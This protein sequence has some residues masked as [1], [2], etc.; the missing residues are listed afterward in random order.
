MQNKLSEF[1]KDTIEQGLEEFQRDPNRALYLSTLEIESISDIFTEFEPALFKQVKSLDLT[2]CKK[3]TNLSGIEV[4]ESLVELDLYSCVILETL[5]GLESLTEI[6]ELSLQNCNSLTRLSELNAL[7]QLSNLDLSYNSWLTDFSELMTLTNLRKLEAYDCENLNSLVGLEKLTQLSHLDLDGSILENLEGIE[8][9]KL[10]EHLDVRN[11]DNLTEITPLAS[12]TSLKSLKIGSESLQSLTPIENLVNLEDLSL[13]W[14]ACNIN[15]VKFIELHKLKELKVVCCTNLTGLEELSNAKQLNKLSLHFQ[16]LENIEFIQSLTNLES[17]SLYNNNISKVDALLDLTNLKNLRLNNNS[18]SN[19]V[20]IKQLVERLQEC[21]I[22]LKGNPFVSSFNL[23]LNDFSPDNEIITSLCYRLNQTSDRISVLPSKV[24][25]LGNHASGKSSL[26]HYLK[27]GE[28][29][30][31]GNSTHILQIQRYD[32]KPQK[33][34]A[35]PSALI[36]DFGGQDYYHGLYRVFMS[37]KAVTCLLWQP[38]TNLNSIKKDSNDYFTQHFSR[39]YWLGYWQYFNTQ[40]EQDTLSWLDNKPPLLLVQTHGD[41]YKVHQPSACEYM[42]NQHLLCLHPESQNELAQASLSYFKAQL[43]ELIEA[44]QIKVQGAIW[45]EEFLAFI[46]KKHKQSAKSRKNWLGTPFSE[47]LGK[48]NPTDPDRTSRAQNLKVELSQLHAQ[49]IV[50]FYPQVN[51]SIVWLNPMAFAY[52]VHNKLLGKDSIKKHLGVMPDKLLKDVDQD[53]IKV[54]EKEKV[55]FHHQYGEFGPE[56]IVPNYLPLVNDSEH[57]YH[58]FTFGLQTSF[59]FGLWFKLYL[60]LGL[61]NQLVCHFGR[62]PDRKKFWRDQLLFTLEQQSKVLIKL[63]FNQQLQI[64]VFVEN[65]NPQQREQHIAYIY[66]VIMSL[67]YDYTPVDN[68]HEFSTRFSKIALSRSHVIDLTKKAK[69]EL[70]DEQAQPP[71]LTNQQLLKIYTTPPEDLWISRDKVN[72]INATA[73]ANIT[74]ETSLACEQKTGVTSEL[75]K[76]SLALTPFKP[77]THKEPNKRL[78]VFISYSH[79]DIEARKALQQY[80]ITLERDGVIDVWQD[81]MIST[82]ADWHNTI[83]EA[84]EKADVAIMLVSQSF[85]GSSYIHSVEMPTILKNMV[86]TKAKIFPVLI[87]QCD[88]ENWKVLPEQVRTNT[89]SENASEVNLSSYQFFP[90]YKKERLMPINQWTYPEEAWTQLA[91]KLREISGN[92]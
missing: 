73:L 32:I 67:Y 25:L 27:D 60:P 89:Q 3:L 88:Y 9:L 49:G 33:K 82:G 12:L 77:F 57:E 1:D 38:D 5:S 86:Q 83:V 11:C 58:L 14:L 64:Q 70:D 41:K 51:D 15:L 50:L 34:T 81:A 29:S 30:H 48:F 4:F 20:E 40:C 63:V 78:K 8:A 74:D 65:D 53:I 87:S 84:L 31:D 52:Y 76:T 26:A 61:I 54:L 79:D 71:T 47:V 75:A 62:L 68:T 42:Y 24:L 45:Y 80:L 36:Y 43:N 16:N 44:N 18:L 55:I 66:H 2:D 7:Q 10:L 69:G 39:E 13:S 21:N 92:S 72:F 37:Q 23:K 28:L 17:L 90:K 56:Y 19:I 6:Q 85:I 59:A 35:L 46:F 91:Q 22:Y